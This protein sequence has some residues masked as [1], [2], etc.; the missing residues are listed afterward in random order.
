MDVRGLDGVQTSHASVVS[1]ESSDDTERAT[2]FCDVIAVVAETERGVPER[3]SL[4][5]LQ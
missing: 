2:S 4:L 3:Y 5:E 1:A